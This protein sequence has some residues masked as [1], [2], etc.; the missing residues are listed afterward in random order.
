MA[1]QEARRQDGGSEVERLK[2]E[3][4]AVRQRL[5]D[6]VAY[7]QA[8]TETTRQRVEAEQ[9]R[10][11]A[12]EVARRREVEDQ[13]ARTQT[14]LREIREHADRLQRRYDE[15]NRQYLQQEENARLNAEEQVAQTRAAARAAWQSAEEELGSMEKALNE[16]RRELQQAQERNRQLEETLSSLQ[17]LEGA[18]DED[19]EAALLEEV[20]TLRKA[21]N[22][23]ER[24]RGQANQRAVRLAEKLVAVQ[25]GQ[26]Q[27]GAPQQAEGTAAAAPEQPLARSGAGNPVPVDLTEANAVLRAAHG[28]DA[29][30]RA[31]AADDNTLSLGAELADEFQLIQADTSLDREKLR[32]LQEQVEREDE[33]EADRRRQRDAQQRSA[34]PFPTAAS[35][36]PSGVPEPSAQQGVEPASTP[37]AGDEQHR[38]TRWPTVVALVVLLAGLSGA[39]FWF[40][41]GL[42]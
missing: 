5:H 9:L 16:A 10:I 1:A 15:L 11:H 39:A 36:S 34:M 40:L 12:Q 13:L 25:A 8:E 42:A 17:G 2:R 22:L 27:G 35:G 32:R 26:E 7:Y 19:R 41:G 37:A 20:T 23:S 4:A 24:G 21:L 38:R 18:S 30:N 31:D 29:E 14:E 6:E 28:D 33:R 3:L